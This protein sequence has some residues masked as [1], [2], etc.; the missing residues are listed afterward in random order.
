M[1]NIGIFGKLR[2]LSDNCGHFSG[3]NFSNFPEKILV[4]FIPLKTEPFCFKEPKRRKF[5]NKYTKRKWHAKAPMY[6]L[7][8]VLFLWIF[9]FSILTRKMTLHLVVF[10][11]NCD[12]TFRKADLTWNVTF[13]SWHCKDICRY[14]EDVSAI[15]RV[16]WNYG[17]SYLLKHF[18]KSFRS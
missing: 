6:F 14:S 18:A 3:L 4:I 16:F 9:I 2:T 5:Y 7:F 13:E 12:V 1:K 8:L 15:P 11:I 10:I 17:S